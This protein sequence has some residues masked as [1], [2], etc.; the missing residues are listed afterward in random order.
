MAVFQIIQSHGFIWSSLFGMVLPSYGALVLIA[1]LLAPDR[2]ALGLA[3]AY[4]ACWS[5]ALVANALLVRRLG[6]WSAPHRA[7][8]A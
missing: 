8:L 7:R 3:W 4:V 2:G 6:V 5:V 1:A